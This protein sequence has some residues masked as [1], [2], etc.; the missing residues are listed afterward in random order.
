MGIYLGLLDVSWII[1]IFKHYNIQRWVHVSPMSPTSPVQRMYSILCDFCCE[2][3][4]QS[5][6]IIDS[7]FAWYPCS[8]IC[9]AT[10]HAL[11]LGVG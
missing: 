10:G 5:Y 7:C 2:L 1:T 6:I 9:L 8:S 4:I 11:G 3:V